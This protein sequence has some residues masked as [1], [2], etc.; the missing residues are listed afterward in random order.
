ML[1]LGLG[2]DALGGG[3]LLERCGR[4]EGGGSA[5]GGGCGR[6]CGGMARLW[7]SWWT[8]SGIRE[9]SEELRI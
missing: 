7:K 3:L 1:L 2:G 8:G 4:G 9:L 6:H 5:E